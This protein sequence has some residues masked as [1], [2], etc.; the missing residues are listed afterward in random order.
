MKKRLQA[1]PPS[2]A[3]SPLKGIRSG[4]ETTSL[5]LSSH[6]TAILPRFPVL[7][8][9]E[10][11]SFSICIAGSAGVPVTE[12]E[13]RRGLVCK[14]RANRARGFSMVHAPDSEANLSSRAP[15]FADNHIAKRNS[16]EPATKDIPVSRVASQSARER[17]WSENGSARRRRESEGI[18]LHTDGW[19]WGFRRREFRNEGL[20]G[21]E[22]VA[23]D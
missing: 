2:G 18:A 6:L 9:R 3:A 16:K 20:P 10:G 15:L 14:P 17:V 8:V 7:P 19:S 13:R 4:L 23:S 21:I 1:R 12:G 22:D 5:I 11:C